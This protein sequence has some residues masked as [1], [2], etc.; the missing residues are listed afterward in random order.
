[1]DA[2]PTATPPGSAPTRLLTMTAPIPT[3][4]TALSPQRMAIL[5][6]VSTG[7]TMGRLLAPLSYSVTI[8]VTAI[9]TKQ[10]MLS[11]AMMM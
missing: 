11:T 3:T 4:P 8:L 7:R 5:A 9:M 1:M 6:T 10:G 2:L